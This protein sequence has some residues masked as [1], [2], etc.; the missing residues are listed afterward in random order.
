MEMAVDMRAW[1]VAVD[2]GELGSESV[3]EGEGD[4]GLWWSA[5]GIGSASGFWSGSC[6]DGDGVGSEDCG[7]A[8]CS[9]D[10]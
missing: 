4:G 2:L 7:G 1:G 6:G 10:W 9:G 3:G 8:E 5:L